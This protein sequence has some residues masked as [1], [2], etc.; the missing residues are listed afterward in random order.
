MSRKLIITMKDIKRYEVLKDVVEKK[1]KGTEASQLLGISYVH[2]S[3]LKKKLALGGF[4]GILRKIPDREP[5]K[6]IS[7]EKIKEII[8]LRKEIYYDFNINHFTDKLHEVHNIPYSYS[9]IKQILVKAGLHTPRKKKIVHRQRRR[10]PKAGMLIQMD[11]SQHQWLKNVP[12][13]WWLIATIDD[14]TNEVPYA[15]FSPKDTLFANMHVIREF[16]EIKGV[17]MALYADKASHFTTTRH[18]GL[19]YNVNPEQDDTQIERALDELDINFISANSPQAK[20]RIEVR[21]RLFQD[22]LIKEMRVAAIKDYNHANKFLIE[23]FLPWH[24]V[25]YTH[26]TESVY[27]PVPVD[28][29]LNTIFCIKKE[30]TVKADNTIQVQGET[31]QIPPSN[32]HLSFANR[33]VEVCILEDNRIFILYKDKII[34]E[35]KLS[36]DNKFLKKEKK[37]EN[38]LNLRDYF[39]IEKKQSIPSKDHPWRKSFAN[40]IKLAQTK[41]SDIGNSYTKKLDNVLFEPVKNL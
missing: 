10:M 5:N 20:G 7:E 6:K 11:S 1:L 22:R 19:H 36:K 16:I 37:I 13:K 27:R 41:K 9:S 15:F 4:E 14:A 30:R 33:I 29:N 2:I 21:F 35:Y 3:R 17:F 39:I 28:K 31:I 38:L 26:K 32:L 34:H 8:N 12:E 25:K 23:T 18:G 40:W 24:N